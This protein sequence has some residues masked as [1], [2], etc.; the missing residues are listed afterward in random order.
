[1]SIGNGFGWS[2]NMRD[3]IHGNMRFTETERKL[4]DS[5]QM[6]RLRGI[7]QLAM[8]HLVYPG[9][10]HTRFEHSLG[11]CHLADRMA[12]ALNLKKD[13]R[14]RLRLAALLHDVGH[15][16]FSHESE[17][18]TKSRLGNHE[19]IGRR[20]IASGPLAEIIEGEDDPK[21]VAEWAGGASFGALI[22]GDIG[23]DRMD[24]LL[25]D[26]HYTGVAYGVI[27]TDRVIATV[28]WVRGRG[29]AVKRSGLEAV[30]SLL[31]ARFEM[32]STVYMH[33]TVRIASAMLQQGIRAALKHRAF[34]WAEAMADG[35][36]QM[37]SRLRGVPTAQGW[38]DKISRREL[39]K[40]AATLNWKKLSRGQRQI[41]TSGQLERHIKEKTHAGVLID[42]PQNFGKAAGIPIISENG[43]VDIGKIS[44]IV[45][46]LDEA[47]ETRASVLVCTDAKNRKRAG[48]AA[49][50][51][52]G[53]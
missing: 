41:I 33:H 26:A 48:A 43:L 45:A 16:A 28:D 46:A 7:R 49:M 22:A 34:D 38:V 24:Y 8:A 42:L 20:M 6:Q 50:R 13:A 18:V 21:K 14:R 12:L 35:D 3:P 30:E 32:F 36:A 1:M 39:Y 27:D 9:A 47:I 4:I 40:R 23:A 52:L 44:P 25:R 2:V 11:T 15:I 5:P 51:Y 17:E 31:L 37:L 10:H 53:I 19:E 29:L